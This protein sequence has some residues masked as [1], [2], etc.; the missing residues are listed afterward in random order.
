MWRQLS[1]SSPGAVD[2]LK[3]VRMSDGFLK[4]EGKAS[5]SSQEEIRKNIFFCLAALL[6]KKK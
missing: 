2:L 1:E 5:N 4:A 3:Q 6:L